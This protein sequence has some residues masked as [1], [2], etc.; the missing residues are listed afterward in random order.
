MSHSVKR[1]LQTEYLEYDVD[2]LE[3]HKEELESHMS[4]RGLSVLTSDL[5][6]LV[7]LQSFSNRQRMGL[8]PEYLEQ[9]Y[10]GELLPEVN[11]CIYDYV[12]SEIEKIQEELQKKSDIA[13]ANRDWKPAAKFIEPEEMLERFYAAVQVKMDEKV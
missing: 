11:G 9:I 4:E 10:I 3:V 2:F 5:V 8:H 7:A 13:K 6:F 1:R 12:I